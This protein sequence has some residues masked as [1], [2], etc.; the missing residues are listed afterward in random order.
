M[1]DTYILKLNTEM[2]PEKYWIKECDGP[3][4]IVRTVQSMLRSLNLPVRKKNSTASQITFYILLANML[5]MQVA[6]VSFMV[7]HIT[8]VA[9]MADTCATVST[10]FQVIMLRYFIK[11]YQEMFIV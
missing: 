3:R 7:L 8:D 5:I 6:H 9:K 11:E 2:S 10:T 4:Y 1:L